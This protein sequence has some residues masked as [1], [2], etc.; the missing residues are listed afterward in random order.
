MV[1]NYEITN[2]T[3]FGPIVGANFII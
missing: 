2:C 3:Y 1:E